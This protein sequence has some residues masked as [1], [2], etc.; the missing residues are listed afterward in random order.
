MSELSPGRT[1]VSFSSPLSSRTFTCSN[2]KQ[3]ACSITGGKI[4]VV[5]TFSDNTTATETYSLETNQLRGN[6]YSSV[7]KLEIT[8]SQESS[9]SLERS[10]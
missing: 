8:P 10:M 9:G 5:W 3:V 2:P 4:I 6:G 1:L 7:T